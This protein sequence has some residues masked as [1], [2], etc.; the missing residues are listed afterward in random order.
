[1]S[2]NPEDLSLISVLM[3]SPFKGPRPTGWGR[4][5][6]WSKIHAWGV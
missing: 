4:S 3:T 2:A 5:R 1:V 6:A